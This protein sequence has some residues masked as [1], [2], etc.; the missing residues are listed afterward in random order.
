MKGGPG[1]VN[2]YP[3]SCVF[4]GA[5]PVCGCS[6]DFYGGVNY[7]FGYGGVGYE[8]GYWNKGVFSCNQA[9]NNIGAR[10]VVA[11]DGGARAGF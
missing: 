1:S 9:L 3:A 11:Y 4:G 10:I 8:G 6:V 5:V 2:A 7:G